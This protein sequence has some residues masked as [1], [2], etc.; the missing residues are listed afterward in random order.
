MDELKILIQA[1]LSLKD[2]NKSKQQILSELPKL[3]QQLQSDKKARINIIAGLDIPKSKSLIQSQLNEL[4]GK[5]NTST[6]KLGLDTVKQNVNAIDKTKQKELNDYLKQRVAL[7]NEILSLKTKIKNIEENPKKTQEVVGYQNILKIKEQELATLRQ[8]GSTMT[9][10]M[11]KEQQRQY[12]TQNTITARERL[13]IAERQAAD[14]REQ[15]ELKSNQIETERIRKQEQAA[16]RLAQLEVQAEIRREQAAQRELILQNKRTLQMERQRDVLKA[17]INNYKVANT[18]ASN[19]SAFQGKFDDLEIGLNTAKTS[20][21]IAKLR[22][23]FTTLKA[24]IRAT[25]KE[26]KTFEERIQEAAVKFSQ[27]MSLTTIISTVVRDIRKMVSTVVE[28]DTALVDLQKTFKGTDSDLK[29]FYYSANN[30]AKQLGV[31]T[32][33]V[34][35]QAAA[36][37][38]LNNIGLLYGNI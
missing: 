22:A 14:R 11:T 21:D 2:V 27:W 28:L 18:R 26:G 15:S 30:V 34:I 29:E 35:N 31:T 17:Q 33:E 37:S 5:P 10:I 7:T 4:V 6:I 23:Q 24:E 19:S 20:E 25:G 16:Q 3:E 36:W 32:A 9:D 1:I 13:Q 8:E 12:I 38:R